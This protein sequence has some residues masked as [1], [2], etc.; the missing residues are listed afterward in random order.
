MALD[1]LWRSIPNL[2]ILIK[3]AYSLQYVK[4]AWEFA[5]PPM[6]RMW[7]CVQGYALRVRRVEFCAGEFATPVVEYISTRL[8]SGFGPPHLLPK[9]RWIRCF[10]L[11]NR[12]A[13]L[14]IL[15]MMPPDLQ[16]IRLDCLSGASPATIAQIFNT[17]STTQFRCLTS[18]T[19]SGAYVA[20]QGAFDALASVIQLQSNLERLELRHV[21]VTAEAL[22]KFIQQPRLIK[23]DIQHCGTSS[24]AVAAMFRTIG[25]SFPRLR[26]LEIWLERGLEDEVGASTIAGISSCH[27]L[28]RLSVVCSRMRVLTPQMISEM[29][30]WWP[31][32]EDFC[33]G[34][35]SAIPS[36]QGA[37]LSILCDIARAWSTTL[38]SISVLFELGDVPSILEMPTKFRHLRSITVLSSHLSNDMFARI[39][40]FLSE[41]TTPPFTIQDR[42]SYRG[43]ECAELNRRIKEIHQR[44]QSGT[45]MLPQPQALHLQQSLQ[46]NQLGNGTPV[47]IQQFSL[48]QQTTAAV[49]AARQNQQG[50]A[51][52]NA[53]LLGG[54]APTIANNNPYNSTTGQ[55]LSYMNDQLAA[56]S[57]WK[58]NLHIFS[59][60]SS[61]QQQPQQQ[62]GIP[63][64]PA[65]GLANGAG[66]NGAG[67]GAL[68]QA[69]QNQNQNPNQNALF[70]RLDAQCLSGLAPQHQFANLSRHQR[71]QL[72]QTLENPQQPQQRHQAPQQLQQQPPSGVPGGQSAQQAPSITLGKVPVDAAFLEQFVNLPWETS[73]NQLI[74]FQ[75]KAKALEDQID[76]LLQL[77][78]P[79][80]IEQARKLQVQLNSLYGVMQQ[81]SEANTMRHL[82]AVRQDAAYGLQWLQQKRQ[83]VQTLARL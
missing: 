57:R 37:P 26:S 75:S 42:R 13:L 8:K 77:K 47:N 25:S 41:V 80:T 71:E 1:L 23:L 60:E 40:G 61:A 7:E 48:N 43:Q 82:Y 15:R 6:D 28:R 44:Q 22:S 72:R 17:L 70:Q 33:L 67:A 55:V 18:I 79:A 66:T 78:T 36:G 38:R 29:R 11:D 50:G 39:A 3:A 12:P 51:S 54:A 2:A 24:Q 81:L 46:P 76:K 83:R 32:M 27:E 4:G 56:L 14:S 45:K 59:S 9:V 53:G 34:R 69:L 65:L 31:F 64:L 21:R 63:G 30:I 5:S 35:S 52:L 74:N 58:P 19:I 49:A 68:V 20:E 73:R 10:A 16:A 62:P